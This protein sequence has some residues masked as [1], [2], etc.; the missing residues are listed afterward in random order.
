MTAVLEPPTP[1]PVGPDGPQGPAGPT[2]AAGATGPT[3]G[4]YL[5]TQNSPSTHW[6][7][8]HNLGFH[9]GGVLVTDSG[10]TVVEGAITEADDSVIAIDFS[11]AF[12]GFAAVS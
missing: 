1:G 2:G 7:I 12:S 10:G 8:N 4:A 3:G 9:P 6:V 5:H 11:V